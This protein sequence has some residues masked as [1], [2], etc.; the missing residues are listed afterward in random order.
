MSNGNAFQFCPLLAAALLS[1]GYGDVRAEESSEVLELKSPVNVII[2]GAG[3]MS[4]G[5]NSM[6]FSQYSGIS[7]DIS[8]LHELAISRRNDLTGLWTTVSARNVGLDTRELKASVRKQGSWSY[9]LNFN[10]IVRNDPY[11][12]HTGMTG[13]GTTSPTVNLIANPSM[14]TAWATDNALDASNGVKGNDVR[15]KLKRTA[16]GLS[17][18]RWL[19]PELQLELSFRSENKKGARMF[20]RAGLPSY[21]IKSNP[22]AVGASTTGGWAVLL[23]PEPVDSNIQ[24]MEGKVNF[25]RD[26]LAMSIGYLGSFYFNHFGSMTPNVP[27]TLNRGALWSNCATV[28]CSTV[29]QLASSP[30]ALPPENHAYKIFLTGTYAIS[31]T[32]RSNF[33]MAYTTAIQ[34][35]SYT[36]MGL[37]PIAP[38]PGSLGGKVTT[39]LMQIGVSTRH[40]Q[41][42]SLDGS[43]RYEDRADQTPTFV[44]NNSGVPDNA[45][46]ATT[47]WASGSQTRTSAKLDGIYRLPKG[48]SAMLGIGWEESKSP[49]PPA[50]T[51]VFSKQVFFRDKLTETGLR[52]EIRKSILDG[53]SGAVGFEYKQRRGN[54]DGWVTTSGTLTNP[55]IAFDPGAAA[56]SGNAGGNY[57]LPTIYMDRDRTKLRGTVDWDA[58]EKVTMQTVM[59]HAQDN[60]HRAFPASITPA[61]LVAVE[62]GAR[63][64]STDSLSL[65]STFR[66]SDDW[67]ISGYWTRSLSRWHVN[68]ANLGDDTRNSN[69][70]IGLRVSSEAFSGWAVTMD[71][72]STNDTTTFTNVVATSSVGGVGNIAGWSGQTLPGNYLPDI[73]YQTE[74][75]KL[76]G[77]HAIDSSS[78]LVLGLIYQHFRTDDWQWGYNGVP[79]LYS[80]NTTVSQPLSQSL[81]YVSAS[82]QLRF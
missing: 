20:G 41:Q 18:D 17:G 67:K 10:E 32:T 78:D 51:A 6:R 13:V 63:T 53:A 29:E 69:D 25:N 75:A 82:Y 28:G 73:T 45:L 22:D 46:N 5:D 7:D 56:V 81:I 49:L 60:Y 26:K 12:I 42:L 2:V 36:E 34:N 44:Y 16:Y 65:D 66:V 33:K 43:L 15:L 14:P 54:D 4:S 9:A 80:D 38:A 23:I 31:D 39:T 8:M 57:V 48:Y 70:T 35:Q 3:R 40:S 55:L 61:Q 1:L 62:A 76:T 71:I 11:I 24:T 59:E 52:G 58:T 74:R 21:T 68:K 77:Q 30:V 37:T 50:N 72:L 79:F 64:I 47:N 27:G 19:T